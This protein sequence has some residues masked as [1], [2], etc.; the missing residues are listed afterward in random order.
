MQLI[1]IYYYVIFYHGFVYIFCRWANNEQFCRFLEQKK[2]LI[3]FDK[4]SMFTTKQ[5]YR[6]A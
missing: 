2:A 6:F 5:S 1:T 3:S 4:P